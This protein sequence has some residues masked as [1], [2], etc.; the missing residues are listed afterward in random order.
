MIAVNQCMH[1]NIYGMREKEGNAEE[2]QE[3]MGAV[4]EFSQLFCDELALEGVRIAEE[5]LDELASE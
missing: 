5:D 2:F 1:L 3:K 4:L